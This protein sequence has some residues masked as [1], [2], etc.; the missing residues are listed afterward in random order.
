MQLKS[1][2]LGNQQIN[3]N[4]SFIDNVMTQ[5]VRN[6]LSENAHKTKTNAQKPTNVNIGTF[7]RTMN[8]EKVE[9]CFHIRTEGD[10]VNVVRGE[11]YRTEGDNREMEALYIGTIG[12]FIEGP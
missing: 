8:I 6:A 5:I 3:L 11:L 4:K 1:L 12:H 10:R 9:I 7:W 2:D